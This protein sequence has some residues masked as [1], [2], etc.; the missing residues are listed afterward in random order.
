MIAHNDFNIIKNARHHKRAVFSIYLKKIFN[1]FQELHGDRFFSDDRSIIGG[2]AKIDNISVVI[3]GQE[4]GSD[5]IKK[6]IHN[7]GMSYPEGYRKAFRLFSMA[8]KFQLPIITFI[9]TPGAHPGVESEER[10]Q[11]SAIANNLQKMSRLKTV[12][13]SV[14]IS[15]GCSGGALGIGVCDKIIMLENSYFS[16]ITPEGCASILSQKSQMNLLIEH[17]S[18]T[19]K[20]LLKSK[21]IDA[22]IYEKNNN[23]K[24]NMTL[25]C[26]RL[27]IQI[28]KYI[29][30]LSI[31]PKNL[32]LK[33]RYK[34][35][36][37]FN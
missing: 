30:D 7:Y 12:I 22:I 5:L 23:R 32:L 8:E 16:T 17:M 4:K 24:F 20:K 21:I 2:L 3:L 9:D 18:I 36:S 26:K 35:M 10:G 27:K 29:H 1:N 13:I 19:P 33:N 37:Q 15:E 14:I 6:H 25:I 28:K 34:R 11:S 31:L